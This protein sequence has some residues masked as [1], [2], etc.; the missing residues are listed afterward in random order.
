MQDRELKLVSGWAAL[1][2]ILLGLALIIVL[3]TTML[4]TKSYMLL[5]VIVPLIL[6][7]IFSLFGFIANA[8]NHARVVTLLGKYAGTL[9]D[10]G[11]FYGIPLYWRKK[12]SLRIRTFETGM[13]S[14]QEIR[15]AAGRVIQAASQQRQPL[16]VNDKDGTPIHI[17]A[18]V[19][20]RVIDAAQ[21]VFQVDRYEDFV[22]LQADAALRNL[23][24]RYSYDAPDADQ[25]SLRAHIEEV[26][27]Q[28]KRDLSERSRQAG[29]EVME[30]RISYLAYAP[31]I[32]AAMLQR[33]QASAIIAART[34]IVEA[35]VG[36]VEHALQLLTEKNIIE[37]DPER[38]AA[39]VSNLLVVLCG[40][41]VPQPILNAGTLH[42]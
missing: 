36:M 30:A 11:F 34:R 26:A 23:A 1:V 5:W 31:E 20:W 9:K 2:G 17:S 16:K 42:N 27:A 14:T 39:M 37:L 13:S 7:W 29:V 33:Q 12:V 24:S 3:L 22:H 32:A 41:A 21:A 10:V 40:H 19:V 8:P 15:D 25:H 28:L 4:S 38:R 18:V 6:A 35:A